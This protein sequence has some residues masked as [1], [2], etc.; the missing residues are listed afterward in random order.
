MS[1]HVWA[2]DDL[3]AGTLRQCWARSADRQALLMT[4]CQFAIRCTVLSMLPVLQPADG[5][6]LRV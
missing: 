5:I 2:C 3:A 6:V 4:F 1:L